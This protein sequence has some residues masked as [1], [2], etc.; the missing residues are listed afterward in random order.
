MRSDE[1]DDR[2]LDQDAGP[3]ARPYTVTGGRTRPS[4]TTHFDLIDVVVSADPWS[5]GTFLA[6][7]EHRRILHL[8]RRPVTVADLASDIGRPLGVV[9][10]LLGDLAHEGMIKLLRPTRRGPVT[11]ERLLRQVLDGLHAL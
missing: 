7:P 11:D 3:V 6:G 5:A 2:W 8:C 10:V 4:G 1:S 9:R